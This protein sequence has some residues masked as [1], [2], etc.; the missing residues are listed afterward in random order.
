MSPGPELK[1]T[2][3][4]AGEPLQRREANLKSAEGEKVSGYLLAVRH[5]ESPTP[6]Y[7]SAGFMPHLSP[8]SLSLKILNTVKL[9]PIGLN[10]KIRIHVTLHEPVLFKDS[11]T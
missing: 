6:G 1:G 3:G 5:L 2:S 9:A 11:L 4:W 10:N 8:L 7:L